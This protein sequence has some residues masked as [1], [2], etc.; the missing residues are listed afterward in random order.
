MQ[1]DSYQ[2]RSIT[3]LRLPHCTEA[4][5]AMWSLCKAPQFIAPWFSTR[6]RFRLWLILWAP[7]CWSMPNASHVTEVILSLPLT[8][9]PVCHSLK[10]KC[11]TNQLNCKKSRNY[12]ILSYYVWCFVHF[13][14]FLK[15][16]VTEMTSLS[17]F[18]VWTHIP[19]GPICGT[20]E[21]ICQ[22]NTRGIQG[23]AP[24]HSIF[25]ASSFL[26]APRN[27]AGTIWNPLIFSHL[28]FSEHLNCLQ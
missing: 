12:A 8:Q 27:G 20:R 19:S 23:P 16:Y 18:S 15:C 10:Q 7:S 28:Q 3:T 1:I 22:S 9:Q 5:A 6:R 21:P 13:F 4:Q 17:S 2:V 25:L 24:S 14:F 11:W 26:T